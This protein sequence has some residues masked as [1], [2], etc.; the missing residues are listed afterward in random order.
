MPSLREVPDTVVV[1]ARSRLRNRWIDSTVNHDAELA[2]QDLVLFLSVLRVVLQADA[3]EVLHQVD[4]WTVSLVPTRGDGHAVHAHAAMV[5]PVRLEY[6][7]DVMPGL[8]EIDAARDGCLISVNVH[9]GEAR[10]ELHHEAV[11]LVTWFDVQGQGFSD[12]CEIERLGERF[13][14]HL[15]CQLGIRA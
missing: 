8:R 5:L 13:P 10:L 12:L 3:L 14:V 15:H 6:L 2:E 9:H 4:I 7:G 1:L 11:N